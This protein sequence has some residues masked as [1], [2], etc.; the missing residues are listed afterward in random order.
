MNTDEVRLV[1]P[2]LPAY[3]RLARL[4]AA[5][6]ASGLG[7]TFDDVED[8]RIAVDELCYLLIGPGGQ[9]GSMLLTFVM[10][11]RQLSITGE[12]TAGPEPAE[13]AE[14]SEQILAAVV[15]DYDVDRRD[16]TVR[17]SMVLRRHEL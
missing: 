12:G 9:P 17:F 7:F 13:L 15:D 11:G 4:T 6:L 5:A 14:L 2:A 8:L 1:L 10:D 3:L 16:G